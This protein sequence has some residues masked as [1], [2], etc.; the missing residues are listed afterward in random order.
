MGTIWPLAAGSLAGGFARW[1]AGAAVVRL[2]GPAF[3]WGTLAVNAFG[4]L[5]IGAFHGLPALRHDAALR[6][7]L[8]TG[9]CGGFTTFSS[10]VLE[11]VE[12]SRAGAPLKA[13]VYAAAS[14]A[15]GLAAYLAGER[16]VSP[17]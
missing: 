6:L 13:A 3:P 7:L 1:A 5:L 2:L 10:L 15:L 4:C 14:L 12:L 8:V 17:P 16:L 9:F 11:L